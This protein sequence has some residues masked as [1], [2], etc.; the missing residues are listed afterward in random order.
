M[1][2]TVRGSRA[3]DA[4]AIH[5]IR[6]D[7]V[8]QRYQPMVP[9]TVDALRESLAARG[10][11]PLVPTQSG[12]VQWTILIGQD[13]AG[14]VSV[15]IIQRD[16][17]IANLGYAVAARF[18]G[19]GIASAAVRHVLPAIFDPEQ[20]DIERLVAVAAVDNIASRRVLERCGLTFEGIARGYLI[21]S[22]KRVDHAMYARLRTDP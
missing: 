11:R 18:H 17:K 14:W 12:K 21:V 19:Q 9:G 1:Q 3:S 2:L 4:E 5:A 13:I 16:H 20:L 22:G 15:D 7:P 10:S 8:T 6:S